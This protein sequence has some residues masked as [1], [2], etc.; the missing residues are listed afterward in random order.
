MAS[1]PKHPQ[2]QQRLSALHEY[3]I[4]DTLPEQEYDDLTLLAANLLDVPIAVVSLVDEERQWFKSIQGL[5]VRETPRDVAFCAHAILEREIFTVNDATADGRFKDNPLVTAEPSIR[6]YAGAP[7]YSHDDLPLG[8]LCVIDTKPR[9]L[10]PQQEQLLA[11]LSRQV[12][13]LL[14]LRRVIGAQERSEKELRI[15]NRKLQT[16][17]D[18]KTKFLNHLSHEIRTP[19]NGILG[20]SEQLTER[21]PKRDIQDPL[22]LESLLHLIHR[23]AENLHDTVNHVLDISRIESGKMLLSLEPVELTAMVD[24]LLA[25]NE[26]RAKAKKIELKTTLAPSLPTYVL[27]DKVK[28]AQILINLLGNAVKFTLPSTQVSLELSCVQQQLIISVADQGEGI[29]EQEL[30]NVFK[31]FHQLPNKQQNVTQGSGLGLTIVSELC[32]FLDG[33]V[34]LESEVG[35]GSRFTVSIPFQEVPVA[36]NI[37]SEVGLH[38]DFNGKTILLVEDNRV[39]QLV[40]QGYL[41]DSGVELAVVSEGKQALAAALKHIPDLILI[42]IR[43]PDMSGFDVLEQL[44]QHRDLQAIPKAFLSGDVSEESFNKANQLGAIDFLVK[45]LKRSKLMGFLSQ[46]WPAEN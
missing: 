22:A 2:E 41:R 29:P 5:D 46:V 4:L 6:F 42:D 9:T 38:N 23:S 24:E 44:N 21:Y 17:A 19:I 12:T 18:V 30:K 15:V 33:S 43:L 26:M 16:L 8:T 35:V 34:A 27:I 32:A 39:N 14:E 10:T 45:P 25:V 28:V 36:V 31:P 20:L 40:V 1:A 37:N 13:S 7:L 11:A 3:R